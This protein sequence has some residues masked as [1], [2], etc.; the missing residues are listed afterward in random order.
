MGGVEFN[1]SKCHIMEVGRSKNRP[2][3]THKM[4]G[5]KIKVVHEEKDLGIKMQDILSSEK[6]IDKSFGET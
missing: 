2:R 1:S 6:H 5:E 3:K 4:G